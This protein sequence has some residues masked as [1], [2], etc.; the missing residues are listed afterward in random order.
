MGQKLPANG[1]RRKPCALSER[2]VAQDAEEQ[3]D[4]ESEPQPF[5]W[6]LGGRGLA[7]N[8]GEQMPSEKPGKERQGTDEQCI[9]AKG[10][11]EVAMK[12]LVHG[13]QAAAARAQEAGAAVKEAERIESMFGGVEEIE[14]CAR[15]NQGRCDYKRNQRKC[16]PWE[17]NPRRNPGASW[18]NGLTH[19]RNALFTSGLDRMMR[20][21]IPTGKPMT[22]QGE[23]Q[24]IIATMLEAMAKP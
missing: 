19:P 13:P 5:G 20:A 6:N 12:K 18:G 21:Q 7:A 11:C 22:Q 9:E 15:R 23:M 17:R 14:H 3:Q 2:Q 1:L 4:Y 16:R 8:P 10:G 24:G